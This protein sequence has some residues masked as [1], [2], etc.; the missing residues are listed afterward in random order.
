MS[1]RPLLFQLS[2][3][4]LAVLLA[5]QAISFVV[6][7]LTPTPISPSMNL[8]RTIAAL[9]SELA[10]TAAGLIRTQAQAPVSGEP[11]PLL[12]GAVAQALQLAR[13]QVVVVWRRSEPHDHADIQV[14]TT[15]SDGRGHPLNPAL[16]LDPAQAQL[17]QPALLQAGLELPPF[18]LSVRQPDGSWLTLEPPDLLFSLWR[19]RLLMASLIGLLALAPVAWFAARR[20]IRPVSDLAAAASRVELDGEGAAVEV[21][22]PAEIRAAAQAFNA[23]RARLRQQAAERTRLVAAVAHD[24]RT[25]LT[26][27]RLRAENAAEADRI[28][29]VADIERMKAM[30]TR[31]VEY[32]QSE[33]SEFRPSQFDFGTLVAD[34]VAA[35]SELGH[36]VSCEVPDQALVYADELALRRA[37]DN[38]IENALR[39]AGSASVSLRREDDRWVLEVEDRGPGIPESQLDQLTQPFRRLDESRNAESGGVGLGLAIVRTVALRHRGSFSLCNRH[40]GGLRARIEIPEGVN[41]V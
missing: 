15:S 31:V 18:A 1:R 22:G 30:I 23:M 16:G 11:A 29:M 28:R 10:A 3:L 39:Y 17:L 37:V 35:A 2:V 25:P 21:E 19:R 4:L 6:V 40:H 12:A 36:A 26:S 32:A 13:E 5:V 38:L 7:L 24:L 8:A 34:S 41:Q 20:L 14:L 27:L 33:Q 9:D